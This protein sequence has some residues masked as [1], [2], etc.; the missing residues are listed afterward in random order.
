MSAAVYAGPQLREVRLYGALGRQ[1]GRLFRLAVRTP[2]EAAEA[3]C[4]VLPGFRKAFLG[5]D[6]RRRY[7]VFVGR[8]QFRRDIG[9]DDAGAPVGVNEPIR[10]VPVVAGAKRA[11]LLQTV[12]AIALIAYGV[13]TENP[14]AVAQGMALL[15][16]GI[17]QLL[18]KQREPDRDDKRNYQFNGPENITDSGV[19]VPV[20]YGRV[21]TGSVVVSQGITSI[22]L[23]TP[24]YGPGSPWGEIDPADPGPPPYEPGGPGSDG[25]SG[26]DGGP[27]G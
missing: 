17:I 18:S 15:L 1:F 8:S 24:W 26:G 4:A 9:V 21:V 27:G 2:A 23:S 6:G 19:A 10:F 25:G 12:F 13:V 16:G 20:C 22:E 5:P 3:L 14:L 11:G 7:H